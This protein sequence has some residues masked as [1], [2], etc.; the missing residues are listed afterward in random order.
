MDEKKYKEY[1]KEARDLYNRKSPNG[2]IK[3]IALLLMEN[4]ERRKETEDKA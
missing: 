3:F 1:E 4:D 2:I